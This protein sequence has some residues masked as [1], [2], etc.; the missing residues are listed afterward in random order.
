MG[1][2][3][4]GECVYCGRVGRLT[5]DHIPPRGFLRNPK[6][7]DLIKVP[8]CTRC[9]NGASLDDEYFKTAIVLKDTAGSHAEAV[10]IRQSVLRALQMPE[11]RPFLLS[12]TKHFR[13]VNLR[14]PGG[15][16]LGSRAAFDAKLDRL[17]NVVCR[18]TRG[19]YWRH[20]GVRLASDF[21]VSSFCEDGLRDINIADLRKI[22]EYIELVRNNPPYILG[23]GVMRYWYSLTDRPPSSFWLFEFYGDVRFVGLVVPREATQ[24][25]EDSDHA[26]V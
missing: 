1:K 15:L 12:F 24:L 21:E 4:S 16:H 2:R 5:V 8:S 7:L 11:K 14:T 26:E 19:L 13:T 3:R 10:A 20:H 23:R 9:N 22:R 25:S 6:P 17:D 18:I